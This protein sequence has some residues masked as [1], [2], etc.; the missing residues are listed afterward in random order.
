MK[1]WNRVY[2]VVTCYE[3]EDIEKLYGAELAKV[4]IFKALPFYD[5]LPKL[6]NNDIYKDTESDIFNEFWLRKWYTAKSSSSAV[7]RLT[8]SPAKK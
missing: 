4:P 3:K 8:P 6:H 2:K 7:T 5:L 1:D